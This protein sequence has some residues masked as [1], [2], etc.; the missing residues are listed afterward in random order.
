[1]PRS[2][3]AV[4]AIFL[5][6]VSRKCLLCYDVY[7]RHNIDV[8]GESERFHSICILPFR[9]QT[10]AWNLQRFSGSRLK[11]PKPPVNSCSQASLNTS[12]FGWLDEHDEQYIRPGRNISTTQAR[13]CWTLLVSFRL[14]D[15]SSARVLRPNPLAHLP[16]L[17]PD[18]CQR[19]S[20]ALAP[21]SFACAPAT[22]HHGARTRLPVRWVT[23]PGSVSPWSTGPRRTWIVHSASKTTP[24]SKSSLKW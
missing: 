10:R 5:G 4:L 16:N 24:C 7:H 23:G 11:G 3:R 14:L 22:P 8:S 13:W 17:R 21:S 12:Q 20:W 2:L 9:L 6:V 15:V 1:M 19:V 18:P